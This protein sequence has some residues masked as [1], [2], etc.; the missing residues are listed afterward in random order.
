M[1]N[2]DKAFIQCKGLDGVEMK[3]RW[4]RRRAC[5]RT[6]DGRLAAAGVRHITRVTNSQARS[7]ADG[8][9]FRA[10]HKV[11]VRPS[12]L[13]SIASQTL[14]LAC[15]VDART[16]AWSLC[17]KQCY[18]IDPSILADA[19]VDL[20][21]RALRH[22]AS[23]AHQNVCA[24]SYSMHSID[25]R[26]KYVQVIVAKSGHLNAATPPSYQATTP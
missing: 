11:S 7:D 21:L 10:L 24:E 16:V 22:T 19:T 9:K 12:S 3:P 15:S 8:I 2:I 13:Q 4:E 14:A 20:P 17:S 25:Q 6:A 23:R 18:S 5:L 1:Q 26:Y